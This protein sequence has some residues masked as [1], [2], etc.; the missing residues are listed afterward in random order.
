M[1]FSY[2]GVRP[3]GEI[4]MAPHERECFCGLKCPYRLMFCY[5]LSLTYLAGPEP[6]MSPSQPEPA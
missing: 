1:C 5:C 4:N 2:S 3:I 6:I